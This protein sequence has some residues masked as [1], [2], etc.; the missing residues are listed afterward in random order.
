[1]LPA[2]CLAG[3]ECLAGS[4]A[5]VGPTSTS[6]APGDVPSGVAGPVGS[7]SVSSVSMEA[8]GCPN[9]TPGTSP[10][11]TQA[12][13]SRG[14]RQDTAHPAF[15]SAP[16]GLSVPSHPLSSALP[17]SSLSLEPALHGVGCGRGELLLTEPEA[18]SVEY[19]V[20]QTLSSKDNEAENRGDVSQPHTRWRLRPVLPELLR[21]ASRK[22]KRASGST[23]SRR[24]A[25]ALTELL[26]SAGIKLEPNELAATGRPQRVSRSC[27]SSV[28]NANATSAESTSSSHSPVSS[29]KQ[30][31]GESG[32]SSCIRSPP[33]SH[34]PQPSHWVPPPWVCH[35]HRVLVEL[36][37]Q[38][39]CLPFFPRVSP[40][41]AHYPE[42][43]RKVY[44]AVPITL[45]TVLDRLERNE[46]SRCEEVF[47][48]VHTVFLCAFRY[49]EPGNQYWMM[50]HEA[51]LVFHNLT[52]NKP[53]LSADFDAC[54]AGA[55]QQKSSPDNSNAS[56]SD[57]SQWGGGPRGATGSGLGSA[58]SSA[59]GGE[60]GRDNF[61][62]AGA[63]GRSERRSARRSRRTD[64]GMKPGK[65][66]K[67][68]ARGEAI[69]A[70]AL[71]PADAGKTTAVL[72]CVVPARGQLISC[73][74]ER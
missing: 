7:R 1:M 59:V 24:G 48:D 54:S 41:D 55:Q 69:G 12:I 26:E 18:R 19:H 72:G 47:N 28:G 33:P 6:N 71:S 35:M 53:L 22:L 29:E 30:N 17:S 51:S 15:P 50:A 27:S 11:S 61:S 21:P 45:E 16:S 56:S 3:S 9:A 65:G 10:Q 40:G 64:G 36:C 60:G 68:K 20:K 38:S 23:T 8:A 32:V 74:S 42:L 46:Y 13:G 4:S 52:H 39:V 58:S 14:D 34:A 67:S 49:Y 57:L 44:P 70:T 31:H 63:G 2:R 73:F 25:N 5:P 43:A 66:R 62:R 37:K